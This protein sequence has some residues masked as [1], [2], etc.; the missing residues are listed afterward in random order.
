VRR[1]LAFV[2]GTA[3]YGLFLA[4]FLYAVGFVSGFGV[5]K[6]IDSG[7]PKGTLTALGIDLLLLGL[8]AVQHSGM[9]RRSF[10][11]WLTRAV[12]RSVE[13]STFVLASSL[14]LL[15][16]FW[17]WRPLPDLVWRVEDPYG[18]ASLWGL[19]ALGWL[20]VLLGTFMIDHAHLF[21]LS[22]VWARLRR[23]EA[24]EPRFQTR[25]LYR[26]VRHPLML[27]FLLAFWAA[28]AMSEGHLLFAVA[29]TGYIV[30]ATLGFEEKDL[31]RYIG[32]PYRRYRR[33]VPA[34]IPRPGRVAP[35]T[36]GAEPGDRTA[37]PEAA[38]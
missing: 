26:Y 21:G 16:L 23:R 19:C 11:G 14:V 7:R 6:T 20:T 34:F 32:E 18:A 12:P 24:H 29:S 10:K 36:R 17:Q 8:F 5:P 35:A 22:Q 3:C 2:Y 33:Q 30:V 37:S 13:R 9:A 1:A 31:E 27:G 38:R 28:P 25:W 4:A 15:L